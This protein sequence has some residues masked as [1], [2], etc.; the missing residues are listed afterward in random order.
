M[1]A[2]FCPKDG[3]IINEPNLLTL[4]Y[5]C[6]KCGFRFAM[7][8]NDTELYVE[9]TYK[10]DST[11]EFYKNNCSFDNTNYKIK[12]TCNNCGIPYLTQIR[13]GAKLVRSCHCGYKEEKE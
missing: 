1:S 7:D 10:K 5:I 4:E 2:K 8:P 9:E 3:T 13:I 12:K 11:Y 6:N